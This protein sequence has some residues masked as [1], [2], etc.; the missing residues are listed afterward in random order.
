MLYDKEILT[1]YRADNGYVVK[2]KRPEKDSKNKPCCVTEEDRAVHICK[3]GEEASK[4]VDEVLKKMPPTDEDA[5]DAAFDE[6]KG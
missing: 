3:T 2:V 1:V 6:N 4:Y 5:F